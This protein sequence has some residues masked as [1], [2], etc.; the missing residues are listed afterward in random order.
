MPPK[1]LTSEQLESIRR[2]LI[3][4]L[5]DAV[6]AE[7]EL[8]H[9]RLRQAVEQLSAQVTAHAESNARAS[10][11]ASRRLVAVETELTKFRSFRSR[12]LVVY[13]FLAAGLS[14]LWSILRERIVKMSR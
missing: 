1:D 13:T 6:K 7:V 5:R 3:D 2:L 8:G 14:L 10:A 11:E 4:P 9:G 12:V